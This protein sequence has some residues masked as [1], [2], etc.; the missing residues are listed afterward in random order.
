MSK[1]NEEQ[2]ALEL[3]SEAVQIAKELVDTAK[4]TARQ[5]LL[6]TNLD[7][8]KIPLICD[9]IGTIKKDINEIKEIME[10]REDDHESRLRAIEKNMWKWIGVLLIIPPIITILIAWLITMIPRK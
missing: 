7:I 4:E 8:S 6:N 10:K 1:T 2:K 9:R 5:M 3:K